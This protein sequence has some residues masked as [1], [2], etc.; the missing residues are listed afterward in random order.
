MEDYQAA[1]L[2]RYYD[3]EIL[4]EQDLR[5]GTIASKANTIYPYIWRFKG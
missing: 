5:T 1:F 4:H 3:T 2:E